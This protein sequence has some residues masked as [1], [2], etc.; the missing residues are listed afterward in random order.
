MWTWVVE[1][2]TFLFLCSG[3]MRTLL[4]GKGGSLQVWDG[5]CLKLNH[6]WACFFT[7]ERRRWDEVSFQAAWRQVAWGVL[8]LKPPALLNPN[9]QE[10][11]DLSWV[12]FPGDPPPQRCLG[13]VVCWSLSLP[14][15]KPLAKSGRQSILIMFETQTSWQIWGQLWMLSLG[16]V[17]ACTPYWIQFQGLRPLTKNFYSEVSSQKRI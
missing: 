14:A 8:I 11:R 3:G 17:Y 12:S 1:G 2:K 7:W 15:Q 9:P 13:T 10:Q 16:K 6:L 5:S 4:R